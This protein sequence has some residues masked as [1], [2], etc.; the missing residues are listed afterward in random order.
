MGKHI[1]MAMS[2]VLVFSI[3]FVLAG[4]FLMPY[5]PPH[6]SRP[7]SAFEFEYWSTNWI[8]VLLGV[9]VAL[10]SMRHGRKRTLRSVG[11]LTD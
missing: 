4:L 3:V 11:N 9:T 2:F 1:M 8:G 7:I 10:V 6:P 5:L